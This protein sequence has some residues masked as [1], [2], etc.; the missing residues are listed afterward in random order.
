MATTI[1]SCRKKN[2]LKY[3]V[4]MLRSDTLSL[5]GQLDER[6]TPEM[7]L[8]Q[9]YIVLYC[10]GASDISGAGSDLVWNL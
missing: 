9:K 5:A 8:K 7:W 6:N 10:W 4:I 3:L 2:K 1:M